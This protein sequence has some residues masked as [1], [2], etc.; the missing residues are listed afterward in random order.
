MMTDEEKREIDEAITHYEYKKAACIDAMKILQKHRGGWI[1]DESIEDLADFLGMT[2]HEI[3][4][5]AT[6][7]SMI[8]RKPVGRHLILVCDGFSCWALGYDDILAHLM[9]CLGIGLGET[10][11]DGRFTLLRI[12]CIGAC[13]HSPAMIIDEDLHGDLDNGKIDEILKEYK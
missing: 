7:Y 13:D 8:Y 9:S 11:P 1:S 12:P 3:E 10:T 5:V 2:T 4:N 6:Y